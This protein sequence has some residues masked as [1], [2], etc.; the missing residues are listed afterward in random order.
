MCRPLGG[1]DTT[2]TPGDPTLGA[3]DASHA[4]GVQPA[5]EPPHGGGVN[6]SRDDLGP[7]YRTANPASSSADNARSKTAISSRRPSQL[8]T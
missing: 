3:P 1:K 2:T 8:A 6:T 4:A 5:D 7:I